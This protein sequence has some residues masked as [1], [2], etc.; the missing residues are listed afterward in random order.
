[1]IGRGSPVAGRPT[2]YHSAATARRHVGPSWPGAPAARG[3]DSVH[4]T[5]TL[6][7]SHTSF[8]VQ[9]LLSDDALIGGDTSVAATKDGVVLLPRVGGA[10]LRDQVASAL[11]ERIID[12]SFAIDERL[13]TESE[14]QEQFAVSRTVVRDALRMLEVRGL[15][16]IRQGSGTTV[17]SFPADAYSSAVATILLRSQLTI[18]DIFMA[19]AALESQL[20][21]VAARNHT[22]QLLD[23]VAAAFERFQAA[24]R[25]RAEPSVV[26]IG[27][28]DFH[29]ELLRAT[30]LPALEVLLRPIQEMM[31]ATSVAPQGLSPR[32]PAAWRVGAHRAILEAVAG[33]DEERVSAACGKHWSVPLRSKRFER[34]RE[35]RIGDMFTSPSQLASIFGKGADA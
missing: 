23:R 31:A 17:K 18:G 5:R 16:E 1:M 25:D 11:E 35:V 6:T 30:N 4:P 22:P 2:L 15:V 26:V 33:R 19:R 32:D 9:I 21:I 14:L 27:H 34:T 20:A 7:S 10:S 29:S 8:I 12:G 24:V 3:S 28:V 13:P